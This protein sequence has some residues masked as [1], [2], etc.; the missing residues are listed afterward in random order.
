MSEVVDGP[1][2]GASDAPVEGL[3]VASGPP[4]PYEDSVELNLGRNTRGHGRNLEVL[5]ANADHR[6]TDFML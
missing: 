2:T 1:A 4:V 5:A 6:A 3:A